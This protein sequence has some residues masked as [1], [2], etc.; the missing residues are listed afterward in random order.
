MNSEINKDFAL[1]YGIMLGDG[2]LSLIYGRQKTVT[3]TGSSADDGPFFNEVI[4]PALKNIRERDTAYRIRK[5]CK[6]IEFNFK[7]RQFFDL[8]AGLGFPVGKKGN[9]LFIP[10]VFYER[11]LVSF[12]IAGFFATDGS[13]VITKNNNKFYPRV[14]A[15][16]IAKTLIK[17]IN[18][19]LNSLGIRCNLYH[20]CRKASFNSRFSD[21]DRLQINGRL[22][23][24][25]FNKLIGFVNPKHLAKFLSIME[26]LE[27][28]E[29]R[30]KGL[31][32]SRM[33]QIYEE[34]NEIFIVSKMAVRR[35]E[36]P[37]S[38]L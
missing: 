34:M 2:C 37:T 35:I 9:K 30:T 24:K 20:A 17:E 31:P 38:C 32:E 27:E 10:D 18:D 7:D 11:H 15:N 3:I 6:A 4:K 19:Y 26:Y 33:R 21:Q 14:E 22:Q 12:V 25:L 13:L 8:M 23:T 16:E 5:D 29:S 1:L 28:Y 36:L